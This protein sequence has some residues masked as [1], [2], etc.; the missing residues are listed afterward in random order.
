M[1]VDRVLHDHVHHGTAAVHHGE[2]FLPGILRTMDA[3][4]GA[5]QA[6]LSGDDIA[7]G[8]GGDAVSLSPQQRNIAHHYLTGDGK[9]LRQ[10]GSADRGVGM[11]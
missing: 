7:P 6:G 1:A 4:N 10:R 9:L 3:G 2:Q 11:G 5:D 8:C